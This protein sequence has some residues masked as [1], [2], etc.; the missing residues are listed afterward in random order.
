[1]KNFW[2]GFLSAVIVLP[3]FFA[4]AASATDTSLICKDAE[5]FTKV[6]TQVCWTCFT[7]GFS[8]MGMGKKPEGASNSNPVCL[9]RD[10]LGVPYPGSK[11]S[12]YAPMRLIETIKLP[13]CSPILA[14]ITLQDDITAMGMSDAKESSAFWHSHYFAFPL[15]EMLEV[16]YVN[17][18]Q[19]GYVDLDLMFL[20][21]IDPAWNN[22]IY[23]LLLAPE[24][25]V[26]ANPLGQIW[27]ASDCSLA[28]V[29]KTPADTFGCA[30][31][32]GNLYPFSGRISG[33]ADN[34][35]QSSLIAQRMIASLHRKG[36]SRKT[37]GEEALCR[38]SYAPFTPRS[39]YKFS[40][41]YPRAE[42]E[43]EGAGDSCCHP[44]GQTT[45]TWSVAAGGR[46]RPGM[47]DAVY[48]LWQFKE[49]CLSLMGGSADK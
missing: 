28:S 1:M 29:D 8:L 49:C 6:I 43:A 5:I 2:K 15:M 23:A 19:D 44:M 25:I 24:S 21:E 10:D 34:V 17:C 41:V 20:S 16:L 30:G 48:M 40:M 38:P 13:Y 4:K 7:E 27:C 37:I 39:Q 18:H 3:L 11:L 9:C 33:Q 14:G 22:D 45:F 32:D 36:I 31:C 12:Y 47:E 42:A 26:F 35:A 46:M